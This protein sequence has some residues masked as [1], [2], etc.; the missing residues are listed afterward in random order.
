MV[1]ARHTPQPGWWPGEDLQRRRRRLGGATL[2]ARQQEVGKAAGRGKGE[3]TGGGG[4]LKK[5]EWKYFVCVW[6]RRVC[7]TARAAGR[8]AGRGFATPQTPPGRGNPSGKAA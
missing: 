4:S 1:A 5:K 6:S 8:G 3:I 7:P 2:R